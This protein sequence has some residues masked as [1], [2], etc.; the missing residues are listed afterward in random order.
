MMQDGI[1]MMVSGRGSEW[2][3]LLMMMMMMMMEKDMKRCGR[4]GG[5]IY[6]ESAR[7]GLGQSYG[8]K[9]VKV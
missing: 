2:L 1:E 6:S 4:I 9:T 8:P 7:T 5:V 3:L